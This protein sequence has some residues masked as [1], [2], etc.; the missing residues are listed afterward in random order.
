MILL[1]PHSSTFSENRSCPTPSRGGIA[2]FL[3][4]L[5]RSFKCNCIPE[6]FETTDGL[7]CNHGA[8]VLIEIIT[9]KILVG[10]LALEHVIDDDKDTVTDGYHRSPFTTTR[11]QALPL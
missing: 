3:C 11:P 6:L 1:P 9:P 4:S 7:S 8:V 2:G 10:L 5:T